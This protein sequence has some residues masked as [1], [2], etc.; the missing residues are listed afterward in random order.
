MSKLNDTELTL[1]YIAIFI[2]VI[3]PIFV[4][5]FI[6]LLH[7]DEHLKLFERFEL[8]Q[9]PCISTQLQLLN[10]VTELLLNHPNNIGLLQYQWVL[11]HNN[12]TSAQLLTIETNLP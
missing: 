2:A 6:K 4:F 1:I 9:R 11:F 10:R 12:L 8:T 5:I 7:K 3:V